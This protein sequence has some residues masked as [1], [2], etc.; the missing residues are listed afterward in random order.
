MKAYAAF[1][2]FREGTN[3]TAWLFRILTNTHINGYRKSKPST[4]ALPHR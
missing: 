2:T 4:G 3:L 1:H